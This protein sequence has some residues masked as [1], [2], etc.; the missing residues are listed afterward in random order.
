MA[1]RYDP[2]GG[3]VG[4]VWPAATTAMSTDPSSF[5]SAA[6]H[7]NVSGIKVFCMVNGAVVSAGK[8]NSMAS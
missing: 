7:A 6:N 5:P 4:A 2:G 1:V 8:A 3:Y